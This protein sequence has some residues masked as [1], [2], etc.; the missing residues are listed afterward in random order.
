MLVTA[1]SK[2]VVSPAAVLL[3]GEPTRRERSSSLNGLSDAAVIVG[4][5]L[6]LGLAVFQ[7]LLAAGQ[8]LGHAAFG[9]K[10]SVLPRRLRVAS[11]LSAVIFVIAFGVLLARAG[12]LGDVRG[13]GLVRVGTWIFAGVFLLSAFANVASSSRWEQRVMAPVALLLAASFF[14]VALHA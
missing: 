8:P 9:G 3:D 12:H 13:A 14:I 4:S 10:T 6:V 11:G 5:L 7:V 1:V 2:S